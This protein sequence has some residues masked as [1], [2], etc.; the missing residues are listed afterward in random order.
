[1]TTDKQLKMLEAAV[2]ACGINIYGWAEGK[3]YIRANGDEYEWNPLTSSADCAEM[4]AKLDINTLFAQTNPIVSCWKEGV[5]DIPTMHHNANHD[6]T[7]DG[8]ETTWRYAAT[9]VAAK[10]GGMK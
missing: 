10:I 2:K 8:K 9:H 7:D 1:M 5:G 3:A 4:C 6:G